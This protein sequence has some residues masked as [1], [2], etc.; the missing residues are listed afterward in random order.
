MVGLLTSSF[1][2]GSQA[3]LLL[4]V[5]L[6]PFCNSSHALVRDISSHG[7]SFGLIKESVHGTYVELHALLELHITL[8]TYTLLAVF[9]I[10]YL[11]LPTMDR[12]HQI[13]GRTDNRVHTCLLSLCDAVRQAVHGHLILPAH[14]ARTEAALTRK[15][16]TTAPVSSRRREK[17]LRR[18][19]KCTKRQLDKYM[20]E[21][22]HSAIA[23]TNLTAENCATMDVLPILVTLWTKTPEHL[24]SK[25]QQYVQIEN[26][27]QRLHLAY[28]ASNTQYMKLY[29]Q[30]GFCFDAFEK[31]YAELNSAGNDAAELK[32]IATATAG[33]DLEVLI[34]KLDGLEEEKLHQ[35]G[36]SFTFLNATYIY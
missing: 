21:S 5:S 16:S 29:N 10:R 4:L 14:L 30:F 24:R 6:L 31:H 32:E 8:V 17:L 28:L 26:Q 13:V 34:A 33:K 15:T 19:L 12:L 3:M 7:L 9:A 25:V 11:A 23:I 27:L 36:M 35:Q 22:F 18:Q 2:T 1:E 20:L